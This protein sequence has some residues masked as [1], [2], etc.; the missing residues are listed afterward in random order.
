MQQYDEYRG[1]VPSRGSKNN[2]KINENYGI[3]RRAPIK[4]RESMKDILFNGVGVGED[5]YKRVG[6]NVSLKLSSVIQALHKATTITLKIE[7]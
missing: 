5:N 3:D 2:E 6:S 7:C 1:G 4:P